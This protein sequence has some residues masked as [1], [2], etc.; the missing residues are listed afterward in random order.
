M[1]QRLSR[2]SSG[3]NRC[4]VPCNALAWAERPQNG[5]PPSLESR[6]SFSGTTWYQVQNNLC[7]PGYLGAQP[8]RKLASPLAWANPPWQG[9]GCCF[10]LVRGPMRMF[11]YGVWPQRQG[12]GKMHGRYPDVIVEHSHHLPDSL[13]KS[14][15]PA[16][17]Q[18]QEHRNFFLWS[19]GFVWIYCKRK[20][21]RGEV[22][23]SYS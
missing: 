17:G 5:P 13:D 18:R 3:P 23:T 8:S 9:P 15:R 21:L 7:A 16:K 19:L 22:G 4:R 2:S 6:H 10:S 1:G 12:K 20:R 11:M 14:R